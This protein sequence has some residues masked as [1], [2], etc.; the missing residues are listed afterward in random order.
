MAQVDMILKL[1]GRD[2]RTVVETESCISV[3]GRMSTRGQSVV[4]KRQS[5]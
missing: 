5:H 3:A 2:K 1:G 4:E